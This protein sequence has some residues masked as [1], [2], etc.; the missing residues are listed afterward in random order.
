MKKLLAVLALGLVTLVAVPIFSPANKAQAQTNLFGYG[1]A[2][3]TAAAATIN[4]GSGLIT[5]EALT[6]AGLA[7]YTMT[8]TDNQITA[9]SIVLATVANGTNSQGT[10][11][12]GLITPGAGSATIIVNNLH[13]TQALNGT[14]KIRF[15]VSNGPGA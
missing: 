14:L 3:S 4:Q 11:G 10:V 5:T 12:V 9:T 8:L 13:A 1:T 7:A 6:T 2:T 15:I